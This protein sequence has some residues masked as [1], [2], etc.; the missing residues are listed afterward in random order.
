[1]QQSNVVAPYIADSGA[2]VDCHLLKGS[3]QGHRPNPNQSRGLAARACT[4]GCCPGIRNTNLG[5]ERDYLYEKDAEEHRFISISC[6]EIF[7][8]AGICESWVKT[9]APG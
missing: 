3:Y 4:N 7:H 1:M 9:P 6:E 2:A 5:G 8:Y